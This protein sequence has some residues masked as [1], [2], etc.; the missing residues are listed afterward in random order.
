MREERWYNP[1][2]TDV[3]NVREING[4]DGSWV[5]GRAGGEEKRIITE[6]PEKYAD[7]EFIEYDG[8]IYICL[9]YTS[10]GQPMKANLG[11][12]F[13]FFHIRG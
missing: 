5:Q 2:R 1:K 12:T 7:C 11:F 3:R 9:L 10:W 13:G 8:V 6:F 4:K